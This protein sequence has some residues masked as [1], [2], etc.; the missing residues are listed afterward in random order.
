MGAAILTPAILDRSIFYSC[1]LCNRSS[2][3]ANAGTLAALLLLVSIVESITN[4][5]IQC[6]TSYSFKNLW[7]VKNCIFLNDFTCAN[8]V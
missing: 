8:S 4:F 5:L 1:N 3:L 7:D 2:S 6:Y